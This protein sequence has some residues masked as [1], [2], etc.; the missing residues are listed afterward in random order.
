MDIGGCAEHFPISI[1]KNKGEEFMEENTTIIT[2][3]AGAMPTA[4]LPLP[5]IRNYYR[6]EE[7]RVF[8][9][10]SEI[11]DSLLDLVNMILDATKR[12]KI[13]L[14]RKEHLLECL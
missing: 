6:D 5:S 8:W 7:E 3:T 10:T 4:T 14:L 2:Q 1:Q 13:S 12:I 11:D 9:V